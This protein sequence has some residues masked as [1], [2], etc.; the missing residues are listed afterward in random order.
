M[1]PAT[2]RFFAITELV[3]CLTDHLDRKGI[4]CLMRT[5]RHLQELCTPAHYRNVPAT[6]RLGK[7]NILGSAEPILALSKNVHHVRELDLG[8]I[9]LVYY[10][11]CIVVHQDRLAETA[12]QP[13]SQPLWLAPPDPHL[14]PVPPIPPMVRLTRIVIDIEPTPTYDSLETCPYFLPSCR[15]PKA[16]FNEV[17][18]ILQL[19]PHL[20]RVVL[21]GLRFKDGRD[22]VLFTT[23]IFGLE[24]LQELSLSASY[25]TPI[26][27]SLAPTV[28]FSC[29]P[30]LQALDMELDEYYDQEDEYEDDYGVLD[31]REPEL[32]ERADE[33]CGLTTTPRRQGPLRHLTS[34]N[35][36][37]VEE[38][39]PEAELISILQHCPNLL[40]F[41]MPDIGETQDTDQLAAAIVE[42]CP[43]LNDL[44]YRNHYQDPM[45]GAMM[46]RI[47]NLLSPQQVRRLRCHETPFTIPGL[48][49]AS[50]FRRHSV[51]LQTLI[52]R[53]CHNVNSKALQA[54]LVEC[55]GLQVLSTWWTGER[56]GLCIDLDD[57]IEFPWN[58]TSMRTLNLTI[59]VPD[60][61]LN[62]HLGVEPYY[63]RPPLTALSVAEK[64]QFEQL[65][66][67]YRQVGTLTQVEV[68]CL[69]VVF[70]NSEGLHPL[71]KKVKR[72]SFPGMLSLGDKRTGRPGYLH[73]LAGLV[74]LRKFNGSVWAG[75]DETKVT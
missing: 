16:I 33:E 25:W 39:I 11:N 49:A 29:P 55:R 45:D 71:S 74:K 60:E 40:D 17:C 13:P 75:N 7:N 10:F 4:S 41:G 73:H 24:E 19:S 47:M 31:P 52:F 59:C 21:K 14:C 70:Y 36:K 15:D 38:I 61:P 53:G 54:L 69:G 72:N 23:S 58:C 30:S 5:S 50:L 64:S 43:A 66:V 12:G 42:S 3:A 65:E 22:I 56:H 68:L 6:Y 34:L 1:E 46:L 57:A 35:L 32:W 26:G 9:D 2:Q 28:F 18:W 8:L 44:T 67:L 63:K 37:E 51:T 48:D 20:Q 27:P 62:R